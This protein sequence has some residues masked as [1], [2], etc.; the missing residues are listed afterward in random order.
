MTL[1]HI[2]PKQRVWVNMDALKMFHNKHIIMLGKG[3][4]RWMRTLEN[5]SIITTL[6]VQAVAA[7]RVSNDFYWNSNNNH[8]FSVLCD[9]S[10]YSRRSQQYWDLDGLNPLRDFKLPQC[11]LQVLHD[12]FKCFHNEWHHFRI[13]IW[14]FSNALVTYVYFP[15][16]DFLLT[17]FKHEDEVRVC[18]SMEKTRHLFIYKTLLQPSNE[19]LFYLNTRLLD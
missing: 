3:N 11:F 13:H 14:F 10:W 19:I 18:E 1:F 16:S 15:M 7:K 5:Y 6:P 4:S 2:L 8:V 12:C 9:S 17:S